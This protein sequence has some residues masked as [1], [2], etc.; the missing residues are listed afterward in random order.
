MDRPFIVET[1]H[2]SIEPIL[3]Q[4]TANRRIARWFNELSEFQPLF[5]WIPGE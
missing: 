2:K 4:K 1:D 3:T 5:K